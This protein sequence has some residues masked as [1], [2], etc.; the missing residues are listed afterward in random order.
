MSNKKDELIEENISIDTEMQKNLSQSIMISN[1]PIVL[2]LI[3]FGYD[4]KYSR[5]VF[6]YLH[7]EDLEE[8]LNYMVIENGIIQHRFVHNNRDILNDICYICGE[9]KEIHLKELSINI[10][11]EQNN[12]S[13]I[14]KIEDIYSNVYIN[15]E[16]E[17]EHNINNNI[18]TSNNITP[19]YINTDKNELNN[20]EDIKEKKEIINQC[21][22]CLEKFIVNENNKVQK[23]GHA[24]CDECWY[25][26]LS[27]NINENK[28]PSIKCLEHK[29]TEKLSDKFI[30]NLLN[31]DYN[32][33]RKYKQYKLELNIL[34]DPNKKLC[35]F[36]NCNSYLELKDIKE[37]YV[38]CLNNH[39]FC[40]LCLKKPHSNIPCEKSI[41]S[42]L[43]EYAQNNFVKKCP[44]CG[45]IIEKQSGCNHITCS[46]CGYQWCW[47]CN[48]KYEENHF[49][50]GICKGF[51]FY[52]PKNEYEIK[53]VMEG[54]IDYNELTENQR[55]YN[56]NE[57][58]D[59]VYRPNLDDAFIADFDININ[60]AIQRRVE[61]RFE[62]L[63]ASEKKY[64]LFFYLLFGH[65]LF[66]P[67][68]MRFG[69]YFRIFYTNICFY[70]NIV[71]LFQIIF[72]NI[73][74]IIPIAFGFC[75]DINDIINNYRKYLRGFMLIVINI[76]LRQ[77]ILVHN[78]LKKKISDK[79][80]DKKLIKLLFFVP[81]FLTSFFIIFPLSILT[82]I[83]LIIF[84]FICVVNL[85]D[86][87]L[88]LNRELEF[89]FNFQI[90]L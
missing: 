66:I 6:Y 20:E 54:K 62:N 8:A 40:F 33:I 65:G 74:M 50:K 83:F 30:F 86:F 48:N 87:I 14:N 63:T 51:Q 37:K 76:L 58:N 2:Q 70:L 81:S 39:K 1:D 77:F 26:F 44:H 78:I 23:C 61:N 85:D 29:C 80:K 56:N 52:Q 43:K 72:I 3:E 53:L 31:S 15:N 55:Q 41:D 11:Q 79:Y 28:L 82:N 5:R 60:E 12:I 22:I 35:P 71:F 59:I 32:L 89:N 57:I 46:K 69:G 7:P 90:E 9:K 21:P 42:N 47:L 45:I 13:N 4:E 34:Q 67:M 49:N 64:F 16:K 27:I 88:D 84:K 68:N 38:Y 73:I 24:F 10:N 18:S 36:P 25:K 75:F 19:Y 17:N